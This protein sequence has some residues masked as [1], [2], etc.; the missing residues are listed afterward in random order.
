MRVLGCDPSLT[1]SAFALVT[2][3]DRPRFQSWVVATTPRSTLAE[4]LRRL[5]DAAYE[6]GVACTPDLIVIEDPP[7]MR[8]GRGDTVFAVARAQAAIMAGLPSGVPVQLAYVGEWRQALGIKVPRGAGKAP[9]LAWLAER[10][11]VLPPKNPRGT[12]LDDDIAD[13]VCVA[14]FGLLPNRTA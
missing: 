10:G 2:T 9:I 5:A 8:Q 7:V 12:L 13:A 4:R 11:Y 14:E 1:R 3:D 6:I